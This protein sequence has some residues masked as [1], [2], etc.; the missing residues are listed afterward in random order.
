MERGLEVLQSTEVELNTYPSING[1]IKTKIEN[2]ALLLSR[3]SRTTCNEIECSE[4]TISLEKQAI[5]QMVA[6][7]FSFSELIENLLREQPINPVSGCLFRS[8][9]KSELILNQPFNLFRCLR[10]NLYKIGLILALLA[11]WLHPDL[12][13][14]RELLCCEAY[15]E[16]VNETINYWNK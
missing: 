14:T 5:K 13:C 12:Y 1:L 16:P 7:C 3:S 15:A 10:S 8:S 6:D 2:C 9:I 11:K 4:L